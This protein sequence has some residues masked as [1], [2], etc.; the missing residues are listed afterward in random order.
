[1]PGFILG[2]IHLEWDRADTPT[3]SATLPLPIALKCEIQ[4]LDQSVEFVC[5]FLNP[6]KNMGYLKKYLNL[7]LKN[8]CHF[9]TKLS[10]MLTLYMYMIAWVKP[11]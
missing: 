1:M 6:R 11:E 3:H 7:N 4:I 5:I 8:V 10:P 2:T 9:Y